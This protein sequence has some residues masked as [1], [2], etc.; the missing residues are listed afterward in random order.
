MTQ[1]S[2]KKPRSALSDAIQPEDAGT[3]RNL[4][5]IAGA[6]GIAALAGSALYNRA[7][8]KRAEAET[9][10]AGSFVDVDGMRLHY[11]DRGE[12]PAVVLLHGNGVTLQDYEASGVLGLAA[13][14]NR[15]IAFDRPGFGYSDRPRTTIWTPAAQA[16]VIAAALKQLGVGP[17]VVVGHS[18]GT[19]VALALALDAPETVSGLILLSGYYYGTARPDVWPLS[20][21]AL[22][23]VGDVM[24]T[25]VSPLAGRLLGPVAIKASFSP[26]PISEKFA[27]FPIALTLRP[28]QVRATAADTALMVPA[29]VA[30]SRRYEALAVP[31]IVMAGEGD[32]IAHVDRHAE[33][34]AREVSGAE[35]RIVPAQG[36]L[37]HYAVPE[38]VVA[39]IR[40][41]AARTSAGAPATADRAV[42]A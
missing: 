19:L 23:L 14:Q 13:A 28:S 17:A 2:S 38:Q 26:A 31:I 27:A 35:L 39:A 8:R 29:A 6:A 40:D 4:G 9:P 36:H 5:W 20:T 1:K 42:L 21:P 10:P 33:R 22:P 3:R 25:T 30:I 15:V 24:A 41:V 11:V 12:G 34:F 18:W 37:F 7:S 16:Q 32:R